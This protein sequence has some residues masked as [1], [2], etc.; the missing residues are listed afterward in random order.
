MTDQKD[1]ITAREYSLQARV[2]EQKWEKY[3]K[4][5][6]QALIEA[7]DIEGCRSLCD[8]SCGTG[9]FTYQLLEHHPELELIR[10]NDLSSS[11]LEQAKD[12]FRE[13]PQISFSSFH[14]HHIDQSDTVFDVIISL[15]SFHN[16]AD[17]HAVIDASFKALKAGGKIYILDWNRTGMFRLTNRIIQFAVKEH[18]DT[19]SAYEL[20]EML[21]HTGFELT[22]I[23]TWSWRY[24]KFYLIEAEKPAE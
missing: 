2:Y 11:M 18:I 7:M 19:R 20:Y 8:L 23:R 16:Y 10:L 3:L 14:A 17:Q 4:H 15:N 13:Y 5:T 1:R 21:H 24:W 12:R 22:H 6:H 9:L